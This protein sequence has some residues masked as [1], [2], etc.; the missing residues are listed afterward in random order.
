[1][2]GLMRRTHAVHRWDAEVLGDDAA[3]A[4]LEPLRRILGRKEA[5]I[6]NGYGAPSKIIDKLG[7]VAAAARVDHFVIQVPTGDMTYDEARR[8][9]DLFCSEVQP[10]LS[11]A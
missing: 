10:A 7:E 11:A 1:M 9:L 8:T 6:E 3:D 2:D 5:V 4:A